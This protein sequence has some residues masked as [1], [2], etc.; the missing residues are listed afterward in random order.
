M[1]DYIYALLPP[2]DNYIKAMQE[3]HVDHYANKSDIWT[4][5]PGDRAAAQW[6]AER[7]IE[8]PQTI[9]DVGTGRGRDLE[10]FLK[11][12]H[13]CTGIDLVEVDTWAEMRSTWGEKLKLEKA[14]FLSYQPEE[15]FSTIMAVGSLH[16]QHPADYGPFLSHVKSLLK[17]GGNFL[18]SV[19]HIKSES[20]PDIFLGGHEGRFWRFFTTQSLR[21]LLEEAGF[22][23]VDSAT[24]HDAYFPYVWAL[25]QTPKD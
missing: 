24:N 21:H 18:V 12:G 5:S 14:P 11:A 3:E 17:P 7:K 25:V 20:G 8:G 1:D 23:W 4:H 13:Q 9:L 19:F 22:N 16:H 15:K 10:V 2:R 6:L